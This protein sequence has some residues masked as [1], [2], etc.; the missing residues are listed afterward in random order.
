M[1]IRNRK[2][3][4][5]GQRIRAKIRQVMV[6]HARLYPFA[7]SLSGKEIQRKLSRPIALSTIYWHVDQIRL[8]EEAKEWGLSNSSPRG[9]VR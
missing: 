6:E 4:F 1:T 8:E 3:Y 9:E 5:C 2:A 7:R